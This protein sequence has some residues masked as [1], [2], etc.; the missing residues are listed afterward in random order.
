MNRRSM[1][2][3]TITAL[4]LLGIWL[5]AAAGPNAR[6]RDKCYGSSDARCA[7]QHSCERPN[8]SR[9]IQPN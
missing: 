3:I 6:E 1:F 5:A 4:L 2:T 8:A 9:P 7:A